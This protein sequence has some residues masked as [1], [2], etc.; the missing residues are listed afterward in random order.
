[1]FCEIEVPHTDAPQE[2]WEFLCFSGHF[3]TPLGEA[4]ESNDASVFGFF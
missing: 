3:A 4:L 1:M 2:L